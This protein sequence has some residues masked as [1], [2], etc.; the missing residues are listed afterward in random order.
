VSICA[1]SDGRRTVFSVSAAVIPIVHDN[2]VVEPIVDS[3]MTMAT[4]SIVGSPM[5]EINEEDELIFQEPIA[6]HE[7]E[8]Q[9][10]PI[11]DVTHDEPPRRSQRARRSAISDDYEVYVSE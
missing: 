7:K 2:V 4:T 3:L 11:Q 10:H 1:H 9:Q 8:Q 6:N 5:A